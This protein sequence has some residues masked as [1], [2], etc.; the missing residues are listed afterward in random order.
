M[1]TAVAVVSPFSF[2]LLEFT[3]FQS[4]REGGGVRAQPGVGEEAHAWFS[5]RELFAL[6]SSKS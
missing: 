3:H 5:C 1:I 6:W 4:H 2:A